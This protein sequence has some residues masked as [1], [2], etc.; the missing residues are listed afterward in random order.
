MAAFIFISATLSTT[1]TYADPLTIE[2]S[3]G[4]DVILVIDT[5]GSMNT[6]DPERISL[7]AAALFMD[8]M[9]TR[10]SRIG[11]VGFAGVVHTVMPLTPINDL[12]TR[13]D[14]RRTISRFRFQ[15]W[16]DIGLA[17]RTAAEMLLEDPAPGNSPMILLFTDGRIDVPDNWHG[18]NIA[19][20]YDDAWW[21]VD[22]VGDFA[23]IYTIGLNHDDGLNVEFLQ[24]VANRTNARYYIADD[25]ALLPQIFNEIFASHIRTS[26]TE[27]ATIITDG[28]T[29]ADV[30]IPIPSAF[31]SEANI[32]MLSTR[33]IVN[34]RLFDPSGREVPFDGETYTLTYANRY[35]MIKV[36]APMVGDWLLSVQGLPEDRITVNLIYNYNISVWANV[37]QPGNI[38]AFFDP[39]LP[40]L[41]QAMFQTELPP[42]QIRSIFDEAE[43]ELIVYDMNMNHLG[44]GPM[45]NDGAMFWASFLHEPPQDIR[46]SISVTHPGFEQ[47][48]GFVTINFD[49]DLMAAMLAAPTPEPTPSPAPTPTP[50]PTPTPP[51]TPP[52]TPVPAPEP[53]P[54]GT[55]AI[56][57][58]LI[59]IAAALILAALLL[60]AFTVRQTQQRVF[61]GHLELRALLHDGNYT[62][63]EVPDLSTFAGQLSFTEFLNNS[64]GQKAEKFI[65][66]GIPIWDIHFQ[67][68]M[69]NNQPVIQV[70]N[71]GTSCQISDNEGNI[72]F[73]KK[74]IW[75]NGRQLIFLIPGESSR[76]EAT[77]RAY[78]D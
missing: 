73:K 31:V 35:S 68:G 34:V 27:I 36:L 55:N 63:L 24:D 40:I 47:S 64:L 62:S 72:Y 45:L 58:V 57:F 18:R 11:I 77:Y 5:S 50:T 9:E 25:A 75:E 1:R 37:E 3:E 30:I 49:P 65:S 61:T 51:P 67:P 6:A 48:T 78:E 14:I 15:G 16:T 44:T 26:I 4:I 20:S 23:P 13:D 46:I 41:I 53:I 71:K 33:P 43:A 39:T 22:A 54:T 28:D 52:P 19:I 32:I 7:E 60:R 8:M 38:G 2:P 76:I 29:Y 21:A 12:S 56:V 59:G 69:Q 42:A 74:F 66:A 17:L 70:T 10:N